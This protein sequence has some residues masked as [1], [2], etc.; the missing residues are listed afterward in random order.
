MGMG[1]VKLAAAI[2][3]FLGYQSTIIMVLVAV[4]FGGFI[5][6]VLLLMKKKGRKDYIPFGP[7][8]ALGTVVII[9]AG[10]RLTGLLNP[11]WSN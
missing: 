10:N 8:L 3:A 2:G 9:I 4:V 6:V 1:D 7:F 11:G 5:G